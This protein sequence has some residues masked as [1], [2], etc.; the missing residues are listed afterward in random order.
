MFRRVGWVILTPACVAGLVGAMVVAS[1]CSP[2][3]TRAPLVQARLPAAEAQSVEPS[4]PDA[5]AGAEPDSDGDGIP[6]RV[7]ACPDEPE[8]YNGVEDADGCP[9]RGGR[10][11]ADVE[12]RI[13]VHVDFAA[14]SAAL[15]A[16]ARGVVDKLAATMAHDSDLLLIEAA[17]LADAREANPNALSKKRAEAVVAALVARGIRKDRL[18]AMGYG[19]LCPELGLGPS[20]RAQRIVRFVIV[21]TTTGPGTEAVGCAAARRTETDAGP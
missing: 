13:L 7:D 8:T 12:L 21:Q 19:A 14:G 18:R 11:D 20:G 3:A 1:A 15:S 9:D 5:D 17:G 10:H 16:D 6:D 4:V 2:P